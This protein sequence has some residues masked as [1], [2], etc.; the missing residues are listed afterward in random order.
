MAKTIWL[1][2]VD[3]VLN[4]SKPAWQQKAVECTA[5]SG[6]RRYTLRYAPSLIDEIRAIIE[7]D[8]CEVVW[9][10]TWCDEAR[11]LERL[12]GF[13]ELRVAFSGLKTRYTGDAKYSAAVKVLEDGHRLIWTDDSEVP[14]WG[15]WFEELTSMGESLLI[16]PDEDLGLTVED[17]HAIRRF[18]GMEKS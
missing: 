5:T 2:D 15:V 1:L 9:C 17:I 10:T 14:T 16:K 8:L 18:I 11:Q 7:S 13:P 6:G 12:W 3:G 4:A